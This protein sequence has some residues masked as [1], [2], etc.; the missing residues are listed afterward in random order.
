MVSVSLYASEL[1]GGFQS[2]GSVALHAL[3]PLGSLHTV[4]SDAQLPCMQRSS[5]EAFKLCCLQESRQADDQ[6]LN[7][8]VCSRYPE[9]PQAVVSVAQLL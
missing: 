1:L 5:W 4:M 7:C 2:V 3:D 9:M 6:L 8:P